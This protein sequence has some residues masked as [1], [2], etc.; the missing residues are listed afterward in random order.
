MFCTRTHLW[1]WV[2]A[3]TALLAAVSV[4]C[5]ARFH[6]PTLLAP[7]KATS[8]TLAAQTDLFGSAP[9]FLY[10]FAVGLI[11]GLCAST[12]AAA[13]LHCKV[14]LGLSLILEVSQ[15][16]V[17]ATPLIEWISNGSGVPGRGFILPF[18]RHGA[19]D[20]LDVVA[21]V[22]GGLSALTV[23]AWLEK[24]TKYDHQ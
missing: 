21:T 16:S 24:K 6:P 18:W 8:S 23:F 13:L 15:Q 12:Q 19:F 9:S 4:Y 3:S 1:G 22:A 2:V 20:A 5:L 7:F 14:W 17:L 11:L 10:T